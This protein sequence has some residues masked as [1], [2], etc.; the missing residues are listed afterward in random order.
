MYKYILI[1]VQIFD[2]IVVTLVQS[3]SYIKDGVPPLPN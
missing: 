3:S 2:V 1:P